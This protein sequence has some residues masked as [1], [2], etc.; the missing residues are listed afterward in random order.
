MLGIQ[1]YTGLGGV[2]TREHHVVR[3]YVTSSHAEAD[4]L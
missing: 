1:F 3:I 2:K 4:D